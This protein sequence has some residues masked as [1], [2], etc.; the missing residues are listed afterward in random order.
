VQI[1][2]GLQFG[3]HATIIGADVSTGK[4]RSLFIQGNVA[5]VS[6]DVDGA[7][8]PSGITFGAMAGYQLKVRRAQICPFASGM[9]GNLDLPGDAKLKRSFVQA[10]AMIGMQPP[11][12]TG[13]HVVPY[14]GISFAQ[15]SLDVEDDDA[16]LSLGTDTYFPLVFGAG[17]HFSRRFAVVADVTIPVDLG[18]GNPAVG[19]RAVFP[20]GGR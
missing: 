4:D 5:H 9:T 15:L 14:G 8:D 17:L 16:E 3:N 13:F 19:I 20:F 12:A 2:A 1:G 11:E 7:A 18:N 6:L 10:G